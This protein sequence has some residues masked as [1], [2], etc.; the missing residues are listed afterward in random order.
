MQLHRDNAMFEARYN[1]GWPWQHFVACW[2]R[3]NGFSIVEEAY[4]LRPEHKAI[5]AIQG[6]FKDYPDIWLNHAK[7]GVEV[8]S[9]NERFTSPT[10]FPFETVWICND[11]SMQ[12]FLASRIP[13]LAWV[14]VSAIT[15]AM[16]C[17]PWMPEK[18]IKTPGRDKTSQYPVWSAPRSWF[19]TMDWFLR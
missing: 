8:K 5:D 7:R 12:K 14:G 11:A 1:A 13:R 18:W 15:G 16:I 6:K 17:T 2:F 9:K 10:D 4:H 19:H 3:N